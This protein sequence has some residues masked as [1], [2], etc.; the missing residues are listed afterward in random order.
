MSVDNGDEKARADSNSN[1]RSLSEKRR[2]KLREFEQARKAKE[3]ALRRARADLAA[4]LK[5]AEKRERRGQTNERLTNEKRIKYALNALVLAKERAFPGSRLRFE[6]DDL[7][8]LSEK[9]RARLD[10]ALRWSPPVSG[11]SAGGIS[12]GGPDDGPP[13]VEV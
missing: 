11:G 6:E 9:D 8:L 2:G 5:E 7:R 13:D 10:Q 3:D 4:A 12:D 1:V